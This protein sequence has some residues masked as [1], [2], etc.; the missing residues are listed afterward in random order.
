MSLNYKNAQNYTCYFTHAL[1]Y[2]DPFALIWYWMKDAKKFKTRSIVMDWCLPFDGTQR[3]S[4]RIIC[5]KMDKSLIGTV[6]KSSPFQDFR[7]TMATIQQSTIH[8]N[9]TISTNTS[10]S[11]T[12]CHLIHCSII[13][14]MK[15]LIIS[16]IGI[17]EYGEWYSTQ[18]Y[19]PTE[20]QM[21]F[22]A[23]DTDGWAY[24]WC[25]STCLHAEGWR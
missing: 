16:W 2:D 24:R 20:V 17:I 18:C 14:L 21:R 4:I 12:E 3:M 25:L 19:S 11:V 13:K 1:L 5:V 6:L 23:G 22:S 15:G 9:E 8:L 10:S 7:T